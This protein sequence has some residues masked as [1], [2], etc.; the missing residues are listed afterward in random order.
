MMPTV[1]WRAPSGW[2]MTS[3]AGRARVHRFRGKDTYA[4]IPDARTFIALD[5]P[6]LVATRIPVFVEV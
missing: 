4:R 2:E 5:Q 3:R 6:E 1:S